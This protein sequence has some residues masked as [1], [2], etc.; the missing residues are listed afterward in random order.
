MILPIYL[1]KGLEFDGVIVYD[2]SKER[3]SSLIDQKL[4]YIACTRALHRL[5]LFWQGQKSRLI[6]EC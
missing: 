3:Y 5:I 2:V 1:E 4:L 6:P